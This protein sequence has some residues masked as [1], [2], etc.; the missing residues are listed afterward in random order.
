M[1]QDSENWELLQTLFDIAEATPEPD[2]ERVLMEYCGNENIVRRTLLIVEGAHQTGKDDATTSADRVTGRI[3]PYSLIRLLGSGGIG[4]VYL[5]QRI[6]GG[7]PQRSALKVLA[8][9]SAGPSFVERFH[10]EQHILASLDHPHITRLLDA[11]LSDTGQPYLVMEYVEGQ[12]LDSYCN[13]HRLTITQRIEIF[14][15]VCEA[16]AYAHRN[17]IVHLDLKPTNILVNTEGEVKL[18]DFGTSKL[19]QTDSLLTTTVLATPAFASPEQLRNEPVTTACDIY[20]LGAI[21]YELLSGSRAADTAAILFDRALNEREPRPLQDAVSAPAAEQRGTS[22]GKLRQLLTGDLAIIVAKC[23]RA[24]PKE[25]YASVDAL[26]EDLR[27]YLDGRSVLARP[28]TAVYRIGK[29]VRRNRA[30]VATAT[31]FALGLVAVLTYAEWK[32]R[33]AIAEGR[34]AQQMQEFMYSLFATASSEYLGS[35][36][37]TV[38]DFLKLGI[39]TLPLYV[40]NPADLR[41][42]LNRLAASLSDND[43]YKDAQP[44]FAR[45]LHEAEASHDIDAE[46][47]SLSRSGDIAFRL[48]NLEDGKSLTGRGLKLSQ[49]PSVTPEVRVGAM[50]AYSINREAYGMNTEENL[51]LLQDALDEAKRQN[52]PPREIASI[53]F[54]LGNAMNQRNN[55]DKAA[56]AY[57]QALGFYQKDPAYPCTSATVEAQLGTIDRLQGRLQDGLMHHR[58]AYEVIVNCVGSESPYALYIDRLVGQDLVWLGRGDEALRIMSRDVAINRKL[59]GGSRAPALSRAIHTLAEAELL[60][61][62]PVEAEALVREEMDMAHGKLDANSR[63]FG[64][65]YLLCAE[66]LVAQHREEEAL[67]FAI[68]ADHAMGQARPTDSYADR[69]KAAEAHQLLASLQSHPAPAQGARASK[70]RG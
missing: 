52:L 3:G 32:Q 58:H 55:F 6:L 14:L 25:R 62:H 70:A 20:S 51:R 35:P 16:V 8:P 5:A 11:G 47:E 33:V 49:D 57:Q 63:G 17:L 59:D 4:T 24:R 64:L 29:F 19:V 46:T 22:A 43:D 10:R 48:G 34:R 38:N 9:H 13:A 26:I 66:T 45:T 50:I 61:H 42:D 37:L 69:V 65:M 54:K 28:Q 15:Q 60:T 27:R 36:T 40:H 68:K 41:H 1:S 39:K 21:L 12:H 56:A 18:L 44:V 53:T 23:L 31:L 67:S 2:R 7:A 30:S